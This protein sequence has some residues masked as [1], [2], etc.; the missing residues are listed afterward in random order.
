[1]N[2]GPPPRMLPPAACCEELHGFKARREPVLLL[3]QRP[4]HQTHPAMDLHGYLQGV[5]PPRLAVPEVYSPVLLK[6]LDAAQPR[7]IA[8][9]PALALWHVLLFPA[10][11]LLQSRTGKPVVFQDTWEVRY[12]QH[13][14]DVIATGEHGRAGST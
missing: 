1:M 3:S 10:V 2:P 5:P 14:R 12:S 9:Q 13:T 11:L 4:G 7:S 8:E 6:L